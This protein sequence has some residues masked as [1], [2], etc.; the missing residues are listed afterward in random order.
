MRI[1]YFLLGAMFIAFMLFNVGGE[2]EYGS[3]GR[4]PSNWAQNQISSEFGAYKD[5]KFSRKDIDN[6]YKSLSVISSNSILRFQIIDG[7]IYS[8]YKDLDRSDSNLVKAY[9]TYF[10]FFNHIV[11]SHEFEDN[12]DFLLSV[13]ESLQFPKE[14]T[15]Q[16]PLI[17]PVKKKNDPKG[18]YIILVPDHYIITEWPRLYND[19]LVANERFEWDRKI[20]RAFWRG[21]STG[22]VYTRSNWKNFPRVKIVELSSEYPALLDAKFTL[23]AQRDKGVIDTISAK[24][25]I[26]MA[27]SQADHVKYKMQLSVEGSMTSLSSELWRLLSNSVML[28]QKSTNMKW[29]HSLFRDGEHYVSV[30]YDMSNLMN[31]V[32]WV[33]ANDKKAQ[34]IAENASN[35][36]KKEV[37]PEHLH[38]YWTEVL[39]EYV[40]H[41]DFDLKTPTLDKAEKIG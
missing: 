15:P 18:K 33:L 19:I 29:F 24:Y 3:S 1:L 7:K 20:E 8:N 34:K 12:V 27:V 22:G 37:T 25:P 16:V 23:L 26:A 38:L 14:F 36:V 4:E 5:K 17:A 28:R 21:S 9:N 2:M 39:S 30:E 10:K 35:V 11:G 41:Q 13:D 6:D 31:K 32:K 40:K